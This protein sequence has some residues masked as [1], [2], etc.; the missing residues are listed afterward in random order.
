MIK[1]LNKMIDKEIVIDGFI[2][3]IRNLQY[4]AFIILRDNTG[5]VQ[6]T[7][8]K[9]NMSELNDLIDHLTLES[10]IKVT[11]K[12]VSNTKVKLNGLEIIPSNILVTSKALPLPIDYKNKH[13][14]LRETRLD[15]RFL[16]LRRRENFLL[17]KCQSFIEHAMREYFIDNDYVEI[18]TPK[19][20][21]NGAESGAEMFS[22]DYFGQKAYL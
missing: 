11:G 13:N 10:T 18:H 4:V 22:L 16:D 17:F 15:Y 1:D 3:K 9:D 20:G 7:I 12:V 14:I 19:I 8:L 5:F 21:K 6:I 2:D